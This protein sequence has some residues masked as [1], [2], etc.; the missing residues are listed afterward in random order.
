M[1]ARS[2]SGSADRINSFEIVVG[3]LQP[4]LATVGEVTKHL[5]M[6]PASEREVQLEKEIDAL[7]ERLQHREVESLD[8]DAYLRA[9]DYRPGPPPPVTLAQ[10]EDLLARVPRPRT[11][12]S[13]HIQK[14]RRLLPELAGPRAATR[15]VL[16]GLFDEHPDTVRFLSYGS[17]LPV[18]LLASSPSQ[19]AIRTQTPRRS[20]WHVVAPPA[21]SSYAAGTPVPTTA[22]PQRRSKA[23]RHCMNA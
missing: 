23:S 10:L 21:T 15:H 7:H 2:T 19:R 5:A 4:I 8:L 20:D 14:F 6:L 12:C 17:P 9:E 3:E 1:E 11:M 18:E 13:S 16:A 22:C